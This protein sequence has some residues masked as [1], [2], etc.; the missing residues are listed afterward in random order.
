MQPVKRPL[1]G[2]GL[3]VVA[4]FVGLAAAL[5]LSYAM[6]ALLPPFRPEDDDTMREFIP[7]AIAYLT[8]VLTTTVVLV[9][10]WRRLLRYP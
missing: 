9:V 8:W 4:V 1:V 7:V 5:G 10:S 6:T 3:L 2:L